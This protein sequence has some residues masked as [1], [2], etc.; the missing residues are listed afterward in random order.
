MHKQSAVYIIASNKPTMSI[1]P[2][3]EIIT[4]PH[5]LPR[6]LARPQPSAPVS[7]ASYDSDGAGQAFRLQEITR[8]MRWLEAERD[9]RA[10]LYKKYHRAANVFDGM[11][12]ALVAISMGM[13]VGGV[14]LLSTIIAA[15]LVIGLEAGALVCGGLG[16]AGKFVSRRLAAK[17]RKHDSIRGVAESKINT[18]TGIISSAL[19]DNLISDAEFTSFITEIKRYKTMRDAIRSK[20]RK[21]VSLDSVDGKTR[22]ALMDRGREEA[23]AAMLKKIGLPRASQDLAV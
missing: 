6:G 16:I 18:L 7:E 19:S 9:A 23:R 11:D 3:L 4:M 2:N 21:T 13:G 17:A 14:G 20:T 12:T 22:E 10:T 1:Y 5:T 15:P 8:L